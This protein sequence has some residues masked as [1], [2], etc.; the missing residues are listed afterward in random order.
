MYLFPLTLSPLIRIRR[1]QKQQEQA[2]K[3]QTTMRL[4]NVDRK[5]FGV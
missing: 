5:C 4:K 2:E 3:L 1:V